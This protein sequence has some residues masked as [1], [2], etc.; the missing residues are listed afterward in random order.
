MDYYSFAATFLTAWCSL[1]NIFEAVLSYSL[2]LLYHPTTKKIIHN[3]YLVLITG[4]HQ[5]VLTELS[6]YQMSRH[7]HLYE[8]P[9]LRAVFVLII[10]IRRQKQD[11]F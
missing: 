7:L 1:Q 5:D 8:L 4:D 6:N 11:H 3:I 9:P 10:I 2:K